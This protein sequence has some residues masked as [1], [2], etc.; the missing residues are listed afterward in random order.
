MRKSILCYTLL[1]KDDSDCRVTSVL[2][3]AAQIRAA[4]SLLGWSQQQ[5]ADACGSSRRT[6]FSFEAGEDGV[7]ESTVRLMQTALEKA[8][9][10]F[11]GA[12]ANEG[13]QRISADS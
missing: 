12:G 6:I 5:L 4:R 1:T 8:G 7:K 11:I 2:A 3:S 9:V 10:R 13:V